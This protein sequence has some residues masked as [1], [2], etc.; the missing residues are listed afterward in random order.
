MGA[1]IVFE[2]DWYRVKRI[3]RLNAFKRKSKQLCLN[4]I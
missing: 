4:A 3:R 1:E 2:Q